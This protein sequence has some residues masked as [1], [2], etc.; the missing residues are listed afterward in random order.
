MTP[1]GWAACSRAARRGGPVPRQ[2]RAR[3]QDH[4]GRPP[5]GSRRTARGAR[6][7][8]GLRGGPRPRRRRRRRRDARRPSRSSP[9]RAGRA[10]SASAARATRT[11]G[12][13]P[14][15]CSLRCAAR[16]WAR[17]RNFEGGERHG[18][19]YVGA[20]DQ[21]TTST[22]FMIFDHGRQRRRDRPEGARADLSQAGL[23]RARPDGD[24][25]PHA[26]GHRAARSRRPAS[27]PRTSPPIG[28]TNQRETAVVWDRNTGE[29]VYNAIVWQDTRTDKICRR[30]LEGRRPGPVPR[31][32][33]AC[34]SRPT[35]P[36]R[37]SRWIL[38]NVDGAQAK[39]EA[40]DLLFGNIDTW[41]HLEPDRRH[42]RRPAHHRRHATPAARC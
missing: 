24:L 33:P 9:A 36:A 20:I 12:P 19:Q 34:R 13:P 15:L 29:A 18:G 41:V 23:G 10:T 16:A 6:R 39:A 11:R 40:G 26:G 25:E 21:G 42:R 14:A 5:A 22:R 30:A 35:S 17:E 28:I 3:R 8:S 37:R 4:G 32:R 7:R 38:D 2:G 1:E 27:A 31:R